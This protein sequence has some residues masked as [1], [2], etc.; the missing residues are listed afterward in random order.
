MGLEAEEARRGRGEPGVVRLEPAEGRDL[1]R[2][3][4]PGLRH[5]VLELARLVAAESGAE[6]VVALHEDRPAELG[7][8]ALEPLERRRG[9]AE[10]D[11]R[12]GV[13]SGEELGGRHPEEAPVG[14]A[15]E[16]PV[17]SPL[18]PESLAATGAGASLFARRLPRATMVSTVGRSSASGKTLAS[19]T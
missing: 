6:E 13:E 8:E 11:P 12:P 1:P 18:G 2:P 7:G 19:Q 3:L 16:G 17:V 9:L 5:E 10:D 15:A 14:P 4:L